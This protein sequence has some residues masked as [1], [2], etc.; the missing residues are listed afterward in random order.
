[1]GKLVQTCKGQ[2]CTVRDTLLGHTSRNGEISCNE[3]GYLH[4]PRDIQPSGIDGTRA[5]VSV[6]LMNL[7]MDALA[8]LAQ[9]NLRVGW[10][11]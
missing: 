6:H 4:G 7:E 5:L 1:M 2:D 9:G 11:M 8:A 10:V 3:N